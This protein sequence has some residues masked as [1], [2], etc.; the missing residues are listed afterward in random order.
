MADNSKGAYWLS[1]EKKVRNPY[2][3]ASMLS[4]G[5]VKATIKK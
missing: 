3:G 1:N 2:Y 4:C 5:Q